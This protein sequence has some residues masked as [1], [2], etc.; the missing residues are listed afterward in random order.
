[1][2]DQAMFLTCPAYLDRDGAARCGLPAEVE[3]RYIMNS[4]DGPLENA[5]I[6]CPRGHH[7]NGPI[8]YL[9]VPEPSVVAMSASLPLPATI[10]E[11]QPSRRSL[12]KTV[13]TRDNLGQSETRSSIMPL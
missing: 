12:R 13:R 2:E 6:R 8:E 4:T 11:Q 5:K 9:T 10:R 3:V 1:M 7:F